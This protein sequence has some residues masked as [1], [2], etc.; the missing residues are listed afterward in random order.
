MT[1]DPAPQDRAGTGYWNRRWEGPAANRELDPLQPGIKNYVSRRFDRLFRETFASLGLSGPGV[2][3]LEVGCAQSIWLP[4][5]HRNFGFEVTGVDY[6]DV[7]CESAREVLAACGV[8][9]EVVCAD[10]FNPP[11]RLHGRFDVIVSFGLVEHFEDTASCIAALAKFLKPGGVVI[12]TIPNLTGVLG[13]L[14]KHLNRP[15]YDVHVPLDRDALLSAHMKCGLEIVR[16]EYF[17]F[18]NSGVVNTMSVEGPGARGFATKTLRRALFAVSVATWAIDGRRGRLMPN[19]IT[20]PYVVCVA[21]K[22]A[23]KA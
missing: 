12:T 10:L 22:P 6:S 8:D 13:L 7:G 11:D 21:K 14:Q 9:G 19:R 3:L 20:S 15:V 1:T 17:L 5:F 23:A 18:T 2:R 16:C 4:Y